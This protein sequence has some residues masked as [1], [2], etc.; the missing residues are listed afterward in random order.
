[1]DEESHKQKILIVDDVPENIKILGQALKYDYRVS[2][3]TNGEDALKIAMSDDPCD[4]ILLD[5]IMPGIDGYEVCERLRANKSTKNVPVIFITSINEVK[6]ETKGLEIGAV[7]YITKP[8]S[9]PIVKARVRTHLELKRHRDMLEN[10]SSLDGLTGI[11][12]RRRFDE[13]L[14]LE[15]KN[16]IREARLLSLIMIDIDYFGAYNNN[17]GHLAGDDCLKQVAQVLSNS[18]NRPKDFVGRYGGEEFSAVLPGTDNE[19]SVF[20]AEMM[21]QKIESMKIPHACSPVKNY[22]TISLGTA[23]IIPSDNFQPVVL[24]EGSDEALYKAKKGGRNQVR[25]LDLTNLF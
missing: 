18:L 19:G 13:V 15:W 6:A 7:D 24:I 12:N 20:V 9:M 3:A 4:L 11:P 25:S 14:K 10:L 1:M 16:S 8:F 17:Y 22:I 21:R 2:F 23:T 5:I